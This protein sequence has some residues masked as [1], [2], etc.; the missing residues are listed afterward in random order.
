MRS[1]G[2]GEGIKLG[3]AVFVQGLGVDLTEILALMAF[4]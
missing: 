4:P 1:G 2:Q 3:N